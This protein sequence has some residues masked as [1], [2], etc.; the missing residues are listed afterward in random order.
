MLPGMH[1][2]LL[3]SALF[4]GRAPA[5]AAPAVVAE[6]AKEPAVGDPAP[7]FTLPNPMGGTFHL[8]D[9]AGKKMAV[10]VFYPKAFTGG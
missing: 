7:D 3:A 9:L 2:L 10:L 5:P 8:A 1:A 6:A 4:M